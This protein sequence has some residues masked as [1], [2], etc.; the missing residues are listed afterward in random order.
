MIKPKS[1]KTVPDKDV[2]KLVIARLKTLAA[3]KRISIGSEGSFTKEE[4]IKSVDK[5]D[6]IGKKI[7]AIQLNYLKSLKEGVLLEE[8]VDANNTPRPRYHH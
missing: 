5:N 4:L 3:D 7:I 8:E 6:K 1:P 2:R